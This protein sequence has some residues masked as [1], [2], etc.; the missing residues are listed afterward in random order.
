MFHE[1]YF[2]VDILAGGEVSV[3]ADARDVS[4]IILPRERNQHMPP[5]YRPYGETINLFH[6]S[7]NIFVTADVLKLVTDDELQAGISQAMQTAVLKF[8]DPSNGWY[9]VTSVIREKGSLDLIRETIMRNVPGPEYVCSQVAAT[10]MTDD[11]RDF[12]LMPG[13]FVWEVSFEKQDHY[14][15]DDDGED[16]EF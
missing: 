16:V 12:D 9:T 3:G 7:A 14:I 1:T 10:V 11:M 5:W 8:P 6:I 2:E 15:D 4:F 13:Q